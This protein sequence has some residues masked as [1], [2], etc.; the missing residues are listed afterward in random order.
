MCKKMLLL[1]VNLL[2]V[3]LVENTYK[4]RFYV[5][6]H[7]SIPEA[8]PGVHTPRLNADWLLSLTLPGPQHVRTT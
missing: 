6:T 8:N 7:T 4:L 1:F 2:V 3:L 5:K